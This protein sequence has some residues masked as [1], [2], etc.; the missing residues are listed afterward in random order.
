MHGHWG[1]HR[2]ARNECFHSPIEVPRFSTSSRRTIPCGII[3]LAMLRLQVTPSQGAPFEVAVDRDTMVIGRSTSSDVAIN[4]RFLSR[5]HARLQRSGSTWLIEDLGSRNGTFVNGIRAEAA[6]AVQPGDVITMS[7]SVIRV[8]EEGM[9]PP[10]AG[11]FGSSA[12]ASLLRPATELL[13][14]STALPGAA[15]DP[16]GASARRLADRLRVINQVHQALAESIAIDELLD[17]ILD[18]IFEHLRPEKGAIYLKLADGELILAAQRP[19]GLTGDQFTLSTSLCREVVDKGMAALVHDLEADARFAEAAS[20]LDTGVRSLAAAP[21]THAAGTLGMIVLSSTARHRVFSEEDLELLT[22]LA[23]VAAMRIRN[24]ALTEEA[25]DRRR[26]QEEVALARQIQLSLIPDHLPDV[27]GYDLYGGNVPS[28]GVSGDYFEVIERLG[29][30]EFVL[31]IVDVSGKGIAASL[32]TAYIEAV[33][34]APIEDGQTPEEVFARVSRKLYRRTPHERFATALLAVLDPAA[35]TIRFANAGHN[36]ALLLR[37]DGTTE[38]LDATGIPLGLMPAAEYTSEALEMMPGDLLVLYTDGIVEASDPNEEEY[39]LPRLEEL[40][41]R[42][43]AEP[44]RL[45]A[46]ALERDLEAFVR[47]VP[48]ADDRTLVMLRRTT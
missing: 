20:L 12:E 4:D 48:F 14:L 34:S 13:S 18:R 11:P 46:E 24:V 5:H 39:D 43:A 15:Q 41:R 21:L 32:V 37:A 33:S 17:L 3:R 30:R 42:H 7:A 25:I 36:P 9:R 2:G 6:T 16:T 22:S 26:L 10:L 8:F 28:R 35:A 23:S 47:G 40:C 29:G 38:Q 1:L 19:V 44:L 27:A 31:F 45:I